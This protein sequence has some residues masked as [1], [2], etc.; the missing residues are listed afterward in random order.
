MGTCIR[1]ATPADAA[2]CLAIYAPVVEQTAI[3]FELIPPTLDDMAARIAKSLAHSLWIVEEQDGKVGGYAYAG[4]FR[5]R[6]AYD[7]T[8][9]TT[10]YIDES[11]RGQGVGRRLYAVLLG[12]L[13]LQGFRSAMAGATL[14]NEGSVRLHEA[15]G[16]ART[17]SVKDAGYKFGRWHDTGFW[18]ISLGPGSAPKPTFAAA[19]L[20]SRPEWA[21][22]LAEH[23]VESARR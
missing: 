20:A 18:Q 7:W 14:P 15:V 19:E 1:L 4:Q 10:V 22:I 11:R 8:A 6:P 17:G 16:F 9:E 12:A 13:R 3:S 5:A 2:A 21:A 23:R